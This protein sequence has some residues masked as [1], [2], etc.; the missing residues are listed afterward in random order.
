[1]F[2]ENYPFPQD[3]RVRREANTLITAGYRVSVVA[4][5]SAGQSWREDVKGVQVFRYPAPLEAN[6]LL[7]YLWEYGYSLS[8]AFVLS[9]IVFFRRG[10][11]IIHA[12]NPPDIF[13]LI[14][15]FYKL[16]GKRFVFDHH[17]LSPEMYYARF[18][19]KGNRLVYQVLVFFEKLSCKSADHVIATNQSYKKVAMERCGVPEAHITVVRNGPDL[20]RVRLVDPDP[21]LRKKAKTIIGFVGVM[22]FTDGVDYLL[23]AL[24]H[25]VYDLNRT[26][27]YAVIIGKGDAWKSLKAMATQ[28]DLDE[29]VW[30][31]GGISDADLMRYLSTADI[32]V[33]PDPFN[34]FNDKSTMIKMTEYMA[35]GKPIVAF[36]L[37]EHRVTAQESA[38]YARPNDEMDIARHI[39]ALMDNPACR[40]RMGEIGVQRIKTELMWSHQAKH[41]LK[42]YE[43]FR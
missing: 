42:A 30:F 41:L 29:Y 7:G 4:P 22:G 5:K 21:E 40:Q 15:A 8:A 24:Q 34:P 20:N 23:R 27:F 39:S 14:A 43:R 11:D 36:D 37:T 35:L 25:L 26:D 32:C 38:V 3:G 9:W 13:V 31:T 6:G 12:H 2:V 1:M 10:F 28:L 19:G 33:D 16:F 18:G 17:D